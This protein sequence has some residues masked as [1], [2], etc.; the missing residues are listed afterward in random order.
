M[1]NIDKMLVF[2]C[3][4]ISKITIISAEPEPNIYFKQEMHRVNIQSATIVSGL[5]RADCT[6]CF[7]SEL[8]ECMNSLTASEFRESFE[9]LNSRARKQL[10][11]SMNIREYEEMLKCF[12]DDEWVEMVE[13]LSFESDKYLF[14]SKAEHMRL[15]AEAYFEF[16][17][18]VCKSKA[19]FVG[20]LLNWAFRKEASVD[21]ISFL[22]EKYKNFNA[23]ERA[24]FFFLNS[25]FQ[26][27]K[28]NLLVKSPK[29]DVCLC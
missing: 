13:K 17:E 26:E 4:V 19:P 15:I 2:L 11:L 16:Y 27:K 18:N 20:A 12:S 14:Y 24:K 21:E 28:E 5:K 23:S 3:L 29:K 25:Y 22:K 10:L 8:L 6:D 9:K 7:G 1:K